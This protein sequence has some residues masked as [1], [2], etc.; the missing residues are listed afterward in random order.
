MSEEETEGEVAEI[1]ML[2]RLEKGGVPPRRR[3]STSEETVTTKATKDKAT[4]EEL[5]MVPKVKELTEMLKH[6]DWR[7]TGEITLE[8]FASLFSSYSRTTGSRDKDNT[9]TPALEEEAHL[10]TERP[11]GGTELTKGGNSLFDQLTALS[12]K[13]DDEENN[14]DSASDSGRV[15]TAVEV[16]AMHLGLNSSR[17]FTLGELAPSSAFGSTIILDHGVVTNCEMKGE[18]NN[19]GSSSG[20]AYSQEYLMGLYDLLQGQGFSAF[21]NHGACRGVADIDKL[22]EGVRHFLDNQRSTRESATAAANSSPSSS[23]ISQTQKDPVRFSPRGVLLSQGAWYFE[24]EACGDASE[25]LPIKVGCVDGR[26]GTKQQSE[27]QWVL[28]FDNFQL[29]GAGGGGQALFEEK[30]RKQLCSLRKNGAPLLVGCVCSIAEDSGQSSSEQVSGQKC[31]SV[32]FFVSSPSAW[33][34]LDLTEAEVPDIATGVGA[35][36]KRKYAPKPEPRGKR[37]HKR[38]NQGIFC[39]AMSAEFTDVSTMVLHIHGKYDMPNVQETVLNKACITIPTAADPIEL[40]LGEGAVS[41]FVPDEMDSR[42]F[43]ARLTFKF[44]AQLGRYGDRGCFFRSDDDFTEVQLFNFSELRICAADME[45]VLCSRSISKLDVVGGFVPMLVFD[46]DALIWPNFGK[47]KFK[48]SQKVRDLARKRAHPSAVVEGGERAVIVWA[49]QRIEEHHARQNATKFGQME[50]K[51]GR[52]TVRIKED[53]GELVTLESVIP[54]V[55]YSGP[56]LTTGCWYYEVELL[57]EGMLHRTKVGWCDPGFTSDAKGNLGVGDDK[58]S[59]SWCPQRE[60]GQIC[61]PH[62]EGM[63]CHNR[64]RH[65]FGKVWSRGAVIGCAVDLD[66]REMR[67]SDDGQ[68]GPN[69]L[70]FKDFEYNGGLMP[71]VTFCGL[72]SQRIKLNFGKFPFKWKGPSTNVSPTLP[73]AVPPSKFLS[74]YNAVEKW[75]RAYKPNEADEELTIPMKQEYW[76]QS[77]EDDD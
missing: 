9:N 37:S 33:R 66:R 47:R 40:R 13:N 32:T 58:H 49:K 18:V 29:V 65:G 63:C 56:L 7:G 19:G 6:A 38:A 41:H 74:Q 60:D 26:F 45:K 11:A 1:A 8:R 36:S 10:E 61:W 4:S 25:A 59:W 3:K 54:T 14:A 42:S 76:C 62:N 57:E 17:P 73:L 2:Q 30:D 67:F 35:S 77:C 70:A 46:P 69:T 51:A 64:K 50:S 31:G 5:C 12:Q 23:G 43:K 71:A 52:D 48:L 15:G 55:I 34:G 16:V 24:L 53:T 20:Q 27:E 21:G 44:E 68:W 72:C 22:E 39:Q 75:I 28:D